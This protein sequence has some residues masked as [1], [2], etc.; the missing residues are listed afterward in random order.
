MGKV[1]PERV[2]SQPEGPRLRHGTI[3][4]LPPEHQQLVGLGHHSKFIARKSNVRFSA[5]G[6]TSIF[7]SLD[8]EKSLNMTPAQ[9]REIVLRAARRNGWISQEDRDNSALGTLEALE[10]TREQL[11]DAL[12]MYITFEYY[13]KVLH[14][15]KIDCLESLTIL[16]PQMR[17]SLWN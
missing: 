17:V 6:I 7:I 10:N 12:E 14:F 11:G 8:A 4:C 5:P 3:P 16:A 9:A 2:C 15:T 13:S 1:R